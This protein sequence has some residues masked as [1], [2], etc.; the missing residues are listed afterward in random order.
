MLATIH[1]TSVRWA[2]GTSYSRFA[3]LI[4]SWLNS[5]RRILD[6][7]VKNPDIGVLS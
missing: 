2:T 1:E 4:C 3:S 5:Q 7:S 6:L